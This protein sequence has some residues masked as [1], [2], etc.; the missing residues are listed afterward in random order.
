MKPWLFKELTV[1]L[2]EIEIR[3][4]C[5]IGTHKGNTAIQLIKYLS[6]NN[7]HITYHGYDVF[8]FAKDNI[9]FNRKEKNG[10]GGAS[11]DY[12][13]N[14]LD[15]LKNV[16]TCFDYILLQGLT[17]DT[18]KEQSFDFV[19]IDGGHSYETVKH[20]YEKV[21]N[22][23][24]II[25]DDAINKNANEVSKFLEEIKSQTHIEFYKRWAIVRNYA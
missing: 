22:S 9:E 7:K 5:E 16:I 13:K 24:L 2:N 18:L 11:F 14:R 1:F 25:F 19:Y 6:S 4:L 8:D 23:K 10:K 20:D 21:L 17:T 3:S 15:N 12:V